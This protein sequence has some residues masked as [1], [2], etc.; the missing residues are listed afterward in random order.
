MN[1]FHSYGEMK[2]Y[3]IS[4]Q[5]H[6]KYST[7]TSK[8]KSVSVQ[9]SFF[10]LKY[11]GKLL[12]P[13]W[14]L[15]SHRS[16]GASAHTVRS[17]MRKNYTK[18][19]TDFS[20]NLPPS[21]KRVRQGKWEKWEGNGR[22]EVFSS[23]SSVLRSISFQSFVSDH[24]PLPL[25]RLLLLL[26]LHHSAAASLW[27]RPS[28][29]FASLAMRLLLLLR[30]IQPGLFLLSAVYKAVRRIGRCALLASPSSAKRTPTKPI[31]QGR[32]RGA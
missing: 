1:E 2:I 13:L 25:P 23:S 32:T 3:F 11:V 15:L 18:M 6:Y 4:I 26:I 12:I 24:L 10:R 21:I 7:K 29:R 16:S 28:W 27:H 17:R 5:V 20:S 19:R 31:A 14:F 22:E 30:S 8:M 9:K